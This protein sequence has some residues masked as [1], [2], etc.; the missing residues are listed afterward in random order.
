MNYPMIGVPVMV[1]N[2]V[3][4]GKYGSGRVKGMISR[5]KYPGRENRCYFARNDMK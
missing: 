4:P 5:E 3:S 2:Y 1:A